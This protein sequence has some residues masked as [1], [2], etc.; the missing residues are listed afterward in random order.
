M[1]GLTHAAHPYGDPSHVLQYGLYSSFFGLFMYA[2]FGTSR[3]IT[4]GPTSVLALITASTAGSVDGNTNVN[5]ALFL[6]FFSGI[7]QLCMGLLHL[8]SPLSVTG[9]P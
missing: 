6:A 3:D 5:D 4:V 9:E 8:G 2:L 7:I 1:N